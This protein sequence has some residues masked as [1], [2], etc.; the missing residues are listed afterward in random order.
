MTA[1]LLDSI[2][3]IVLPFLVL[4]AAQAAVIG[5]DS[6]RMVPARF[7]TVSLGVGAVITQGAKDGCSAFCVGDRVAATA[8]HCLI[9]KDLNRTAFVFPKRG[10]NALGS[11]VAGFETGTAASHVIKGLT[12]LRTTPPINVGSDWALMR[13]EHP[14]C[15]GR[16][17]PLMDISEFQAF[18]ASTRSGSFLLAS[19]AD[20]RR[21]DI[22]YSGPCRVGIPDKT[23]ADAF[24]RSET[25]MLHDC[26]AGTGASGGPM[27]VNGPRGVAVIGLNNGTYLAKDR[28]QA[29]RVQFN[30]GAWATD[31][32]P[33]VSRLGSV[34]I[35]MKEA[36]LEQ[37][38]RL[39]I[40]SGADGLPRTGGFDDEMRQ[41]I[42]TYQMRHRLLPTGLPERALLERLRSTHR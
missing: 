42:S 8:A 16:A 1:R 35:L 29:A 27:L 37:L 30:T 18:P 26:D 24:G 5:D 38:R 14:I 2:A 36:D 25:V 4:N 34:Q 11:A 28:G 3:G 9:G 19:H 33:L 6:R 31:F 12:A 39:L 17:F 10:E 23:T 15:R 22:S 7:G 13:L 40:A 41:A 21:G 32:R 20:Y